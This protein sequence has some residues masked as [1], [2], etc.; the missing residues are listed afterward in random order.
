M[1]GI[2]A[3]LDPAGATGTE[4]AQRVVEAL[5]H[6]GPD[7]DAV[8]RIG[9]V[10]LAHTR[11]AIIDV[12][13]GDQPLDSEDRQITAIVNG[14]IYNHRELRAGLEERGHRFATHSD[15]EV[16]VHAYEQHGVDCVRRLNGIFA[17]ALWD[18]RRRRLFAARDQ[19]GVKPLYWWSDGRRV[20]LASEIGALLAAGVVRPGV[21]RVALDHYL[22]CRFVPAPRTL[23]EGISKLPPASTLV[24][25]EHAAPRI[26]SW[27]EA[28][29]S[30]Y[31]DL[32]D[33]E[34]ARQLAERFVDAVERQMMSDVPYGA[35]LSGG[36]DSA[37]VVA[38]MALRSSAP[39]ST[40][41]IGFPGHGP[42]LDE[43]EYAAESARLI[44]TEHHA[45]VMTETDFLAELT[46]CIP[47]LEEPCGIP[48]A[49]AL[50]QLSRFAAERVKV[51]LAG[52]GA[53]EPHGG[54]G[55]HQ[56]AALLRRARLVPAAAAA[57]AAALARALPRAAR[58]RRT[59]HLLGGR[60]EAERLLRLVEITDEPVRVALLRRDGR[61]RGGRLRHR[62]DAGRAPSEAQAG[63]QD[64]TK[65]GRAAAVVTAGL[66]QEE[67]L[68]AAR[69]VLRDVGGR[70]LLDQALYLDTRMFLPD[71]ILL[72]N[73]KMSM[74]AGLELRVP[75][76]D[77][78]LMRFVERIP[79]RQRV[80]PRAG[81]RLHR[82]AMEQ[83][84]PAGIADRPKHG[85][86]T[87]YDGWLRQSL[88]QEVERR[89]A[90]RSELADLVDPAA[91]A[92]LVDEHR[93]GRADH[94]SILYCLL[95]LSEWHA[96]FVEVPETV[97]A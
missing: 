36:V 58:A 44:G 92:R 74:A 95:E 49:P 32:A 69:D 77:L 89:Y 2:G 97:G 1:C 81:K 64:G 82:M 23:F 35:F 47:R 87:P 85:F 75:F 28:P 33:D 38:A 20:A 65:G 7:G 30:P 72:C 22:A 55:R 53:D 11:L 61:G 71:G 54:Y 16:V 88:G 13:G 48:S 19:F 46:R 76:L 17:F 91:V 68:A 80:R 45:T 21:D 40:F 4:C 26:E 84:L 31:A 70:N 18:E 79:A 78:E 96:A 15:S 25:E 24:A 9:P 27:R 8:R 43:R 67:R 37:A 56:A 12:Q 94:K 83:L 51:V 5:R 3:I 57:P 73:D 34:L 93:R 14:E 50:L 63:S 10:T 60:G 42:T 66:A 39:P 59:A 41:T 90:S 6:R 62:A 29:G 86:S 52:Q